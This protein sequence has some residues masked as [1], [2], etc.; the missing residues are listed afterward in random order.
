MK[1]RSQATPRCFSI[2]DAYLTKICSSLGQAL[3]DVGSIIMELL[4]AT[5]VLLGVSMFSSIITS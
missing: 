4:R 1:N 3:S 2:I 5:G